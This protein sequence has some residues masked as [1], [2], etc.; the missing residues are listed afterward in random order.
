MTSVRARSGSGQTAEVSMLLAT[1]YGVFE[2]T[3]R[4]DCDGLTQLTSCKLLKLYSYYRAQATRGEL[5]YSA[6]AT[7]TW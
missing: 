4:L 7:D 6:T 2:N 3:E 5:V 1:R